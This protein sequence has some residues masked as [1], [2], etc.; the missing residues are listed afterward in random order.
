MGRCLVNLFRKVARLAVGRWTTLVAGRRLAVL[1]SNAGPD[2]ARLA[3]AL[4]RALDGPTTPEK[5]DWFERIEALRARL[6]AD[7]SIVSITDYGAGSSHDERTEEQMRDGVVVQK[8]MQ[9]VSRVSK[10]SFWAAILFEIVRE[11]QPKSGLEMGTCLGISASYQGSAM[12]LNGSGTLVTLEGAPVLAAVSTQHLTELCL[13]D[14]VTVVPGRFS[15]TLPATIAEYEPLD[16]A[17]IDGHHDEH[18]TIEYFEELLPHLADRAILVFDDI[19]WTDGMRRAWKSIAEH[20]SVR[21]AIDLGAVGICVL[22]PDIAERTN[23]RI[24]FRGL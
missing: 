13:N 7:Q 22:D 6:E 10:P 17:F 20:S 15:D 23:M 11:Y 5:R 9:D 2:G 21:L 16:Y 4:Q 14:R 1:R 3:A 8:K 12:E 18:A 19:S 24:S